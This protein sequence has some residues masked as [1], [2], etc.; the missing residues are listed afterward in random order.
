[1]D[2]WSPFLAMASSWRALAV[3]LVQ[4]SCRRYQLRGSSR[5]LPCKAA[6]RML[7]SLMV[8]CVRGGALGPGVSG[9]VRCRG[10]AP[11]R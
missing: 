5:V 9:R 1:M 11:L 8:A 10:L 3:S 2:S 4:L 7:G 6:R